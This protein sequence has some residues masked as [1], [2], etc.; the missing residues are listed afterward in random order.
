MLNIISTPGS[1][2]GP[3]GICDGPRN[4]VHKCARI[5]DVEGD[6]LPGTGSIV[7]VARIDRARRELLELVLSK[8]ERVTHGLGG[9]TTTK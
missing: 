1:N 2:G 5:V 7:G 8:R 4:F 6:T 3:G 9:L